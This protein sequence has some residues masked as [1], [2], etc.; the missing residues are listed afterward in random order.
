MVTHSKLLCILRYITLYSLSLS[1]SLFLSLSLSLSL[2]FCV[3]LH[4]TVQQLDVPAIRRLVSYVME[5]NPATFSDF[6]VAL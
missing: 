4:E 3:E 1:L 5:H 6:L 2:Y